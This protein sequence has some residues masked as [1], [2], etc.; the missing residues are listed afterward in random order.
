[1]EE[2]SRREVIDSEKTIEA[3]S[4]K[5]GAARMDGDRPDG[6][7]ATPKL[8]SDHAHGISE[9]DN[10]NVTRSVTSVSIAVMGIGGDGGERRARRWL[11]FQHGSSIA[12][13]DIVQSH[14]LL[15][16]DYHW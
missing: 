10:V 13:P 2:F 7:S 8:A 14:F 1:M 12:E 9:I 3:T 11:G 4:D 16:G 15:M 6:T 5:I